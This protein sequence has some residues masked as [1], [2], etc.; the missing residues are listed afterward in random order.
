M[1][2][3]PS[4]WSMGCVLC[5]RTGPSRLVTFLRR[6]VTSIDHAVVIIIIIAQLLRNGQRFA[7]RHDGQLAPRQ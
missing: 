1:K 7:H 6:L 4:W 3:G 5:S 2:S